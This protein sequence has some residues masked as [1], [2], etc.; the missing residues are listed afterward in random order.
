MSNNHPQTHQHNGI[1][2]PITLRRAGSDEYATLERLAQLDSAPALT[3]PC[4]IAER[5]L[6]PLAAIEIG[7]GRVIADPFE[8]T[9][10]VVELLEARARVLRHEDAG[11]PRR[12]SLARML[13]AP[14]PG[15]ARGPTA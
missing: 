4:L 10:D 15:A 3:G 14:A 2:G 11:R 1:D 9:A 13:S 6:R 7:S 12:F 8:R 5:D